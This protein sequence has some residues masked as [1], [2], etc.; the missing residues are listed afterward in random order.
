MKNFNEN[1]AAEP[2]YM[3]LYRRLK[4]DILS[5][6]YPR[7]SRLPSKRT[8]AAEHG[9]SVITVSHAYELLTDEGYVR[10]RE[11]SGFFADFGGA[12][13][14][15]VPLSVT[16]RSAML[17]AH[18]EDFPFSAYAKTMRRVLSEQGERILTRS[19]STGCTEL[20]RAAASYLSRSRGMQVLP[21]QIVVGAG[22]EYL[23]SLIAQLM[24]RERG[25]AVEDPCYVR[26][27]QV[28]EANGVA[29]QALP[30]GEDGIL[31][32]ALRGMTAG[33]LHVTPY[34]SFPSGVTA[35]ASKRREYA[36]WARDTGGF[37]IEDDYDSEFSV[38]G[39][40][41]ETVFSLAPERVI[42]IHSFSRVLASALRIGCMV[43]PQELMA[44][45]RE[46]LGFYSCT[47]PVY[48]QLVLSEFMDSGAM[49]RYIGRR[50]R[51]LRQSGR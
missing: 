20:R 7:G 41:I 45:Y 38:A 43:L 23:Y 21:E 28:Y 13:G 35:S 2:A 40:E 6:V 26:I 36:A 4:G 3:Q 12:A 11:R 42:Y 47:V 9:V 25:F 33:V 49:E 37:I 19:P 46:R 50:K 14:D 8:L 51:K 48:E 34:H 10:S 15:G 30:L 18:V 22:A 29:L 24:G 31:S 32:G 16:D 39:H 17:T 5:G 27:R 1:Q 44:L